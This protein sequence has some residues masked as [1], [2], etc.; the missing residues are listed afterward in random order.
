MA[1]MK[2]QFVFSVSLFGWVLCMACN[3]NNPIAKK[4]I[5]KTRIKTDDKEE[6]HIVLS[7]VLDQQASYSITKINVDYDQY[8][9]S[10]KKY[11]GFPLLPLLD[12]TWKNAKFDTTNALVIFECKDGYNPIMELSKIYGPTK[13]FIVFKDID[14]PGNKDW[15]DSIRQQFRPY[16]LVWDKVEKGDETFFWPYGL[17]TIR[18]ISK[19]IKSKLIAPADNST[20]QQGYIA[21]RNNCIKC[22]SIN[23]IGGTVGPEFNIPKNI[24]E[25][26]DDKQ[27]ISFAKAPTSY[28]YNSH[29]P[30]I[31]NV[32]DKD[33]ENIILYLKYMKDHKNKY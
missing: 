2:K 26:W 18:L 9:K 4:N 27:I 7:K 15:P 17:T 11:L 22:H 13:G 30:A 25:Y 33:F 3:N 31:T 16:Y 1:N 21:F 12:S 24:T 32:S 6:I 23:K 8:F 20:A 10:P 5:D 29:M 19:N 14:Q 28:R